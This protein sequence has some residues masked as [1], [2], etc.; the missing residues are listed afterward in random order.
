MVARRESASATAYPPLG[1]DL[2]R[3][4]F[5]LNKDRAAVLRP[6]L[7]GRGFSAPF[8]VFPPA[9]PRRRRPVRKEV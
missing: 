3:A 5:S 9:V 2:P 4:V 6:R 8:V 7:R 1:L